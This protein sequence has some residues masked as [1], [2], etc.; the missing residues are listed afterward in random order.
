MNRR[1]QISRPGALCIALLMLAAGLWLPAGGAA[2][3][4][5]G[6]TED[7]PVNTEYIVSGV[8]SWRSVTIG[9]AGVLHVP[10]GASLATASILM[11]GG[12]LLIEG[13][14]LD[15]QSSDN[16]TDVFIS[17]VAS[18]FRLTSGSRLSLVASDG[19]GSLEL[20]Q[21]G[22][23]YIQLAVAKE[24]RLEDSVLLVSG[25]RGFSNPVP[26]A[27][28]VDLDGFIA[29]GGNATVAFLG[30][31]SI[32]VSGMSVA[33]TGG[34]GGKAA[35]GLSPSGPWGGAGGGYSNGGRVSGR[36]G[37]GG[38]ASFGLDGSD[39]SLSNSSISVTGGR[40]GRA[41]NGGGLSTT[42][43]GQLG[44]GGGG[45]YSGGKGGNY[46][47]G[48]TTGQPN[49]EVASEPGGYVLDFVGAGGSAMIGALADRL[50][51]SYLDISGS[52]GNGGDAG[53]G[54]SGNFYSG[55]GG[56]GYGGGGGSGYNASANWYGSA[57]DGGTVSGF[58]GSGGNIS[59]LLEGR[60]DVAFANL[61]MILVGGNGG[62]G[63]KGGTGGSYGGGGG[64]GYGGAG[65]GP[66]AHGFGGNGKTQDAVGRGGNVSA[67]ITG[68]PMD[69][70][71]SR[72]I[73]LGGNGGQGGTGGKGGLSGGGG[74]GG[75]GGGGG[76][77]NSLGG[78]GSG[79]AGEFNGVGGEVSLLVDSSSGPGE[80]LARRNNLFLLGG[81]GGYGGLSGEAG[82]SAGGGGGG[83]A[84]C[85]GSSTNQAT[86][87]TGIVGASVGR[88][89]DSAFIIRHFGP[90]LA[91]SNSFDINGGSPGN[92]KTQ[93]GLGNVGGAGTGTTPSRGKVTALV[94]EGV[95][96]PIGPLPGEG[97]NGQPPT[98]EWE[99]LAPSPTEDVVLSYS[100]QVDNNE[101]FSSPEAETEVGSA[102]AFTPTT[103]LSQGGTYWWRVE[104]VYLTGKTHGWGPARNFSLNLPPVYA[105]FITITSFPEDT[106]ADGLIDLNAYFTDDLYQDQLTYAV[107]S[108]S[109]PSHIAAKV[110]GHY[111][112]FSTPTRDWFG[113][114]RF[115][116]RA[117]DQLGLSA[118]SRAFT[119]KV[120]PV[121][122]PPVVQPLPDLWLTEATE[123][124]YDLEPYV[125]DVDTPLDRLN[126]TAPADRVRVD[127]LKLYVYYP[128]GAEGDKLELKVGD[129]LAN[130]TAALAVHVVGVNL[131]PV[132]ADIPP[133]T[134]D[135]D[136]EYRLDLSGLIYDRET[137]A[138][139][140]GWNLT[141]VRAGNPPVF[142]C[143]M[144]PNGTVRILP[145]PDAFGQGAFEVAA[146]DGGGRVATGTV[147]V[148]VR[149]VN[150]PPVVAE[151]PQPSTTIGTTGE[152]DLSSYLSDVD[153]PLRELKVQ[154][155]SPA[156]SVDGFVLSYT[157]SAEAVGANNTLLIPF[158]VSDGDAV[159]VSVLEVR[160]TY[161]PAFT[162]AMPNIKV[163]EG[164]KKTLSLQGYA[165]DKDT[166]SAALKWEVTGGTGERASVLVAP[167][168]QL[169]VVSGVK[170]GKEKVVL[171]L[172][173]QDGNSVSQVVN[174]TVE[175]KPAASAAL[176]GLELR[177]PFWAAVLAIGVVAY[178]V[179]RRRKG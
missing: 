65:G 76:G 57:C 53:N 157:A 80:L 52:G 34:E 169:L 174:I 79:E 8:E 62:R 27:D 144:L 124:L 14:E 129:G 141:A 56:G 2:R 149:P 146:V 88:G 86:M 78:P 128:S 115:I 152:L 102:T 172:K 122:D 74:G 20:G 147:T 139:G 97:F 77:R 59:V 136:T 15:M 110:D 55:G 91:A 132:L 163:V 98:F 95:V 44:A 111:L 126:V 42:L 58:V 162:G 16:G 61:S 49:T 17:G 159:S 133:V 31:P 167:D 45:G 106:T 47:T 154:T 73:L 108:E 84:G 113:Q 105:K 131:P 32:V 137:P 160:L 101:S 71:G 46:S 19:N 143:V 67:L 158:N 165:S 99:A 48:A 164:L 156:A 148:T 23:A 30:S 9:P 12:S 37:A 87:P 178:V 43:D 11:Q 68:G 82:Q 170:P 176:S 104:A 6:P 94:P 117:T 36:I 3:A 123:H 33:L 39:L 89:A 60:E 116:V 168:S 38:N 118:D 145:R 140:I 75:Y 93:A 114:E 150:D 109:D 127:G 166:P 10:D 173:D 179:L 175:K 90:S 130:T 161:P 25:G 171:T 24:A 28:H 121:N 54:G 134:T 29:A 151:L 50:S 70:S 5:R 41:G 21:G 26:W 96:T 22:D 85:G 142:D 125:S 100:I 177:L 112:S 35:D 119:V 64:G 135:E 4:E 66:Y 63:G 92:G 138:E 51:V 103:E 72:I 107:I 7:L 1:D 120:T 69:V 153:N 81:S 13:G 18:E 83:Y 155:G 40:G